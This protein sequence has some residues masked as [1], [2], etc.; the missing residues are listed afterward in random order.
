MAPREH[1]GASCVAI[2]W[3]RVDATCA[4]ALAILTIALHPVALMLHRP[5]WVD[6]SWVAVLN[7]VDWRRA[8]SLNSSTPVGWL[9][10]VRSVPGSSLQ[11]ARLLVLGFSMASSAAAYIL[12][13]GLAWPSR[14]SA[15]VAAVAV[16]AGVSCVPIA[17]VRND[18][19]QYT[20]DAFF[21]LALLCV[22][23]WVDRDHK[24]RS[25]IW[26]GA[27]AL[28]ASPFS[29]TSA[30]VSVA[31]F[32]GVLASALIARPRSRA[33]ATVVVGAVVAVGFLAVFAVTVLPHVNSALEN[34][35]R[36]SYLTGGVW[37]EFQQAWHRLHDLQTGLAMPRLVG[38]V[39]FVVG[40]VTLARMR[41]T[42]LAVALPLLW[43]EMFV[44]GSLRR[45]PFLD[46]RTFHFVLIPSVAVVAVGVVG[47]VFEISRRV[48]IAGVTIGVLVAVLFSLGV[49]PSWQTLGIAYVRSASTDAVCREV[50]GI[51]RHCAGQQCGELGLR[52]LLA[53]RARAHTS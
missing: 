51:E 5:Y 47:V 17:L 29:T 10:L 32:G 37:Q 18:L 1:V 16:A 49:A 31:C 50:H 33:I 8:L 23:R 46:Q 27:A 21:A 11:R 12:A 39:L 22:V 36:H 26:L 30:F 14:R 3:D 2:G 53:E 52:L 43:I 4:F 15:R 38:I 45:Y 44:A 19:K 7:R 42:A 25:V 20:G 48:P 6:E 35:W 24:P 9:A 41:E 40:T 34:Y 28:V 13:R